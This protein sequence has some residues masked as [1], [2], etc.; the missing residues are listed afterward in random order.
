MK[1]S[2][3]TSKKSS[4]KSTPRKPSTNHPIEELKTSETTFI[5]YDILGVPKTSTPDELKKAYRK[6][7]LLTHPDK[8]PDNKEASDNFQKLQKAYSILSDP[9]KRAHYDK[10]GDDEEDGEFNSDDWLDAYEYYRA[11][12]PEIKKEDIKS[13]AEKYKGSEEETEDL[14]DFY[15]EHGGDISKIL[16]F[17]MVSGQEDVPRFIEFYEKKI[18]EGVI[19]RTKKYDQT[20]GKIE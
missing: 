6:L 12:H 4:A 16:E 1:K 19:K 14:I 15:E 7:A 8:N 13:F 18:A 20:K 17:I 5:L 2:A 10:V 3:N 9:K 11:M